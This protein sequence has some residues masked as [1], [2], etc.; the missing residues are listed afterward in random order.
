MRVYQKVLSFMALVILF[1]Y[2]IQAST[3]DSILPKLMEQTW[4]EFRDI[5]PYSFQTIAL[6]HYGKDTCVF[7]ISEPPSWVSQDSIKNLFNSYGGHMGIG[8]HTLGYDGVLIDAIGYAKLDE[9]KFSSFEKKLLCL[10]YG[11]NYRPYYTNL[12][13]PIPHT[14]YSPD[15]LQYVVSAKHLYDIENAPI[16]VGSLP[17]E[18]EKQAVYSITSWQTLQGISPSCIYYS[19]DPGY[20]AWIFNP[21]SISMADSLFKADARQFLL[22]TDLIIGAIPSRGGVAL[23]GRERQT[24]VDVL[25]PL[26]TETI[27]LLAQCANDT[28][29]VSIP[30]DSAECID[31]TIYT[32]PVLMSESLKHSE[33]GCIMLHACELLASYANNNVYDYFLADY[34]CP[35]NKLGSLSITKK[36]DFLSWEPDFDGCFHSIALGNPS[37][38]CP[39]FYKN[40]DDTY[41]V[42]QKESINV[43]EFFV[44]LNNIDLLRTK[45]YAFIYQA[46]KMQSNYS[47]NLPKAKP[48]NSNNWI[49][50][51]SAII[52]NSPS[53][54]IEFTLQ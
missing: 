1:S 3:C 50:T 12:D 38:M 8:R 44:T 15:T 18:Q 28:L 19:K 24:P 25:P 51:P 14:Y 37:C 49:N 30:S 20:I 26:R 31:D 9:T 5:H 4:K 6:K 7:V 42:N 29:F 54:G 22:N 40:I 53:I 2:K 41:I 43:Y 17:W 48:N 34:P 45:Q 11:S 46:F 39:V 13:N 21:M 32:V 27:K 35:N 36:D 10:I 16:F 47:S 23:I 33:L 52:T